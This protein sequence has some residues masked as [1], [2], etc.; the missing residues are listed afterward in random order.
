MGPEQPQRSRG[1]INNISP[2]QVVRNLTQQ[3]PCDLQEKKNTYK[4]RLSAHSQGK[5][6]I[7]PDSHP[8]PSLRPG[9]DPP[10]AFQRLP[11]LRLALCHPEREFPFPY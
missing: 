1:I 9:T 6:H 11:Q 8:T 2:R 3:R 7:D 4:N 10:A 5:C